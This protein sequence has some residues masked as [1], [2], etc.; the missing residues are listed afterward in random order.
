MSAGMMY[1]SGVATGLTGAEGIGIMLNP[2]HGIAWARLEQ[3]PAWAA[4]NGCFALGDRFDAAA[5]L[6]WLETV[7]TSRCLF[8]AAPD[9]LGDHEATAVRS[10]PYLPRIRA[11]GHRA[12]YVAQDGVT[13]D[14]VDWDALDVLFIGGTTE[15]KL[16]AAAARMIGAAQAKGKATHAGRV[17]SRR[18][19]RHFAGLGVDTADGTFL[20]FGPDRRR[21][22][23]IA[24][25]TERPLNLYP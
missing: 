13:P 5:W 14:A 3:F 19:F 23:L 12:A 4:D 2:D 24:W 10:A 16:G 21:R 8:A 1:L 11:L 6:A 18:R 17:N 15:W 20:A 7:P 9:V 22:E 25:T